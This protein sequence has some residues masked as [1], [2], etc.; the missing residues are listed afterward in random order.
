MKMIFVFGSNDAGIHGAGAARYALEHKGARMGK[1]YGHIGD[2]FAIPTKNEIL[3]TLPL[4]RIQDYVRGFIAYANGHRK[5]RF[6]VTCIGCGLAGLKHEQIA[7]MFMDAP[8]NCLF[9]E[10]WKP[11]LGHHRHYWGTF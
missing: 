4:D 2:S 5:L 7:P 6:Q 10:L 9:D 8:Q 3:E 11:L 1:S